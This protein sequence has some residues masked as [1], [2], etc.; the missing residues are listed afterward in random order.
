MKSSELGKITGIGVK[1]QKI[2]AEAGIL[3]LKDLVYYI[4]R[5]YIDRTVF[6][7][8]SSLHPDKEANFIAEVADVVEKGGG[9]KKRL[10]V[11]VKDETGVIDLVYFNG[12]SFWAKRF[13]VG[14]R[15]SVYGIPGCFQILQIVHP[16]LEFLKKDEKPVGKIVPFYPLTEGM[17]NARV[18]HKFI[19]KA[20]LEALDKV[21]FTEKIPAELLRNQGLLPEAKLLRS[22]H[23]PDNIQQIPLLHE[24]LKWRELFPLCMRMEKS[25][26]LR[27]ERGQAYI[28]SGGLAKQLEDKLPFRLTP[29]QIDC[30]RDINKFLIKPSQFFGILQGDVGSGKTLVAV[31]TAL[32]VVEAGYQ[33]AIMAPT[34]ILALQQKESIQKLLTPF[35][36]PVALLT[37]S[38][39]HSER[40]VVLKQ[41]ETGGISVIIG[42]HA[43]YSKDVK[44]KN[45]GYIIIDEQHR[46]GV[47]QRGALIKKGK[48]PDVLYMSAT[49]IPRTLTQTIYGDMEN[50]ILRD[51]PFGR[52]PVQTRVVPFLKRQD[53][54]SFVH[55][56]VNAKI[57]V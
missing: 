42:T 47:A 28:A 56:Q 3:T 38:T 53:M 33:V 48:D 2:L 57:Q 15:L 32:S 55:K 29:G 12:V 11:Q 18:E 9:R 49:P 52:K 35:G 54:F 44:Y 13:T 37:G 50:F 6:S 1:R 34:E 39:G 30:I 24:Q 45:L 27:K 26:L 36:I 51:M 21:G 40:I 5:K 14:Q 20:V 17:Q 46:Y 8:I 7:P 22:L 31:T 23:D 4:P 10:I 25:I 19:Q 43:L 41:L 16:Q